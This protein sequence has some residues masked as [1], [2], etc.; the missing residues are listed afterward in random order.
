MD[1]EGVQIYRHKALT[2]AKMMLKITA[3]FKDVPANVAFNTFA[4]LQIRKKWVDGI[5][6][7]IVIEGSHDNIEEPLIYFY[8]IPTPLIM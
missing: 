1:K 5:K 3:E 8:P 4:D 7:M 6:D 2:G